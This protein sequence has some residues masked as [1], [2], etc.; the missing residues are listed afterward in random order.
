[1]LYIANW[2][3]VRSYAYKSLLP[4]RA[5]ENQA[6]IIWL[7]RTG[8]DGKNIYHSGDS[9]VIDPNGKILAQAKPGYDELLN[10]TLSAEHLLNIRNNFKVG[11]RGKNS[12]CPLRYWQ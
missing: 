3:E 1:M 6:C 10:I 8:N 4:A 2:P 12:L 7:N 9:M 5:I 11:P